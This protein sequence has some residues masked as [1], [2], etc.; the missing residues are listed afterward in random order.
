MAICGIA[1]TANSRPVASPLV[2][3]ML[4]ALAVRPGDG[5]SHSA[6]L[7]AGVGAISGLEGSS[8]FSSEQLMVACDANLYNPGELQSSLRRSA[9]PGS[10]AELIAALYLQLGDS[11]LERL[12]GAFAL[13]V[14]DQK[15]RTLLLARDRFGVKPLCY[16]MRGSELIFASYPRGI[17][18]SGSLSRQP[19]LHALVNYLN[20]H[21]VPA[22]ETAF[23]GISKLGPG[24]CLAWRAGR[25][26]TRRYWDLH[27]TE[28]AQGSVEQLANSLLARIEEAVT[29]SS[30][31]L[32]PERTGCFL[33]GGTDSSTVAGLASR[34]SNYPVNTF[35]IGFEEGRFNEI[36]YARLAARHFQLPHFEAIL[37]PEQA[38][39]II[40]KIV[41]GYDEPFANASAIPT[42]WCARLAREN[43]MQAMLAGDGG[44]E[45]FGGNERYRTQQIFQAYYLL[46]RLA[47][48]L[49]EPLVFA[50]PSVGVFRKAQ[51]YIQRANTPNPERYSASRLFQV[52]HSGEVLGPGMPA[53]NGDALAVMRRYYAAAPARSEINR[54]LY[55]DIKMTLGDEDLPKVVRTAELAGIEVRFPLLDHPLAEFSGRLPASLKVRGLQKRYLFKQ[56]TRNLLPREI[57]AKKKH[58]FGLP[59]GVWL[60]TDPQLRGMSRDV[61]LDPRTYQRGYFQ[62]GFI[63]QLMANMEQDST[64]YFGDLLWSFL[65][66][67]LWHRTHVEQG[68]GYQGFCGE[69][70]SVAY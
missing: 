56:A 31:G 57:L 5:R 41:E 18:A 47:R 22:P 54:L 19:N 3:S 51:R 38:C 62:R 30:A 35:S 6:S 39:Q 12:R 7:L 69:R 8:V 40:P 17:L 59:I 2:E 29:V 28:N 10:P 68:A 9:A 16:A 53:V 21:V 66:L 48:R 20:Y 64:P 45:L 25:S 32:K 63:E 37:R 70:E 34:T 44:D 65:M 49:M 46:P 55:I 36:E 42:Y 13:A 4:S 43:G 14:W 50:S 60:K 58:G 11:F 67:E 26:R 23:E 15:A 61:L 1:V 27:Y 24:E 52:F 33:S